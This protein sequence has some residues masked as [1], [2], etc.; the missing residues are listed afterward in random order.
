VD[1]LDFTP[2]AQLVGILNGAGMSASTNPEDI[3]LPGAWVTVEGIRALTLDQQLQ[4]ECVVYL[5]TADADYGRAYGQLAGLFNLATGAGV[6]PD[7]V[8]RPQGVVMPGSSIPLP[9]LRLPINLL[10]TTS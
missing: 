2:V 10:V 3:N 5:I 9:A 4:L 1:Q 6:L 8:V 7:D